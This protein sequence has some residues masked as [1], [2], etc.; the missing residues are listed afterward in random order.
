MLAVI[1]VCCR[2]LYHGTCHFVAFVSR[3]DS[4]GF[5]AIAGGVHHLP[6]G[7]LGRLVRKR[8]GEFI[9]EFHDAAIPAVAIQFDQESDLAWRVTV[10][11]K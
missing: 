3:D 9:R 7:T 10:G 1:N 4:A 11:L 8:I 6:D 2:K 5:D